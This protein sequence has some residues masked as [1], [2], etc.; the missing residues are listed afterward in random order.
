M[1]LQRT[2]TPDKARIQEV[3]NHLRR[4][5]AD[6]NAWLV[7]AQLLSSGPPG[8]DLHHALEQ[9]VTLLPDNYQSWLLAAR[10]QQR[11]HGLAAVQKWLEDV[12]RQRPE[13]AAPQL[14]SASLRAV[15]D[16]PGAL[17]RF[18]DISRDFPRD[19]RPQIL[20]ADLLQKMGQ[21]DDAV[22]CIEQALV[23][24]PDSAQYWA[25]LAEIRL[26][27]G[28]LNKAVEAANRA[29]ELDQHLPGIR[30]IRG[31]AYR[32]SLNWSEALSDYRVV[33]RQR[34]RDPEILNKIG[35]CLVRL[36]K[37]GAA[38][39]LFEQAVQLN[40]AL[41]VA[42]LN[43]GLLYATRKRG[44]V[45]ISRIR[46][47][48]LDSGLDETNRRSA[49][50]TLNI[51]V[52]HRRLKPFLDQAVKNESV[53]EL[54][55]ALESTPQDL[56]KSD[57]QSVD[58]LRELAELCS[59]FEFDGHDFSYSTDTGNLPFIEAWAQCKKPSGDVLARAVS[60]DLATGPT[61][62]PGNPERR[63][64][65]TRGRSS[66]LVENSI[67]GFSSRRRAKRGCGIGRLEY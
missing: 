45:A 65:A 53:G 63:V 64:S 48:L 59:E 49:Q 11:G 51:L 42:Q 31:E 34:P 40:P 3:R 35:T 61:A 17:K 25:N 50:T 39:K 46:Q 12:V 32:L 6:G 4:K 16:L 20:L 8:N 36:G 14:A 27:Q 19:A 29:I 9:S 38:E 44:D 22:R 67:P 24:E 5:P 41:T 54:Q 15:S 60:V 1:N 37:L 66:M 7:L 23:I 56:L 18:R 62:N 52:E 10:V 58:K 30:E 43:L 33:D 13:L 47:A 26:L 55:A 57:R 2:K 28:T 21:F